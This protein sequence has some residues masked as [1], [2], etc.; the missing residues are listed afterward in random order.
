MFLRN[1]V[2]SIVCS[3][4]RKY[5]DKKNR[6]LQK[7]YKKTLKIGLE[8]NRKQPSHKKMQGLMQEN[9]SYKLKKK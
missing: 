8:E 6:E 7:K 3:I 5:I 9:K 4:E 1:L 2:R